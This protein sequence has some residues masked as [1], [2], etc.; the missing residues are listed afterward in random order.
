MAEIRDITFWPPEGGE[1]AV[2]LKALF[3]AKNDDIG[4]KN[5]F[6]WNLNAE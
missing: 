1:M 6:F 2:N 3:E 4:P 5:A